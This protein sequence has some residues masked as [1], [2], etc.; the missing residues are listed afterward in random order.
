MPGFVIAWYNPTWDSWSYDF[1]FTRFLWYQIPCMMMHDTV[2]FWLHVWG[3]VNK[4]AFNNVHGY[5]HQRKARS[6]K[7]RGACAILNVAATAYDTWMDALGTSPPLAL[8]AWLA[9]RQNN[10]WAL[11]IPFHTAAIIFVMGHCGYELNLDDTVGAAFLALNP[12]LIVNK[13]T[14]STM[15]PMDHEMHHADP[16]VNFALFFTWW[17]EATGRSYPRQRRAPTLLLHAITTLGFFVPYVFYVEHAIWRSPLAFWSLVALQYLVPSIPRAFYQLLGCAA[18]RFVTRLPA[19]DAVRRDFEVTYA[20]PGAPGALAADPSKRYIF[21]YQP[22]GI[23]A[24]GA[25]YTF[26]GKGRGSPVAALAD[27][28]LAVLWSLPVAQQLAALCGCCDASWETLTEL[29]TDETPKSVCLLPG[30]YA[31]SYHAESYKVVLNKR[32]GF[33]RLAAATGASLVPVIGI[34]EPFVCG[35][36]CDSRLG[37]IFKAVLAYRPYPLKLVFGE[38]LEV[39]EGEKPESLHA[40]Y[41]QALLALAKAHDVPLVIAE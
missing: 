22:W 34:G 26:A 8:I 36:P 35:E 15:K 39:R 37:L 4:W 2:F 23:Q 33:A 14:A 11:F 28:K 17:D 9:F 1:S 16:R 25:W 38:P 24:R 7:N 32:R 31:E 30:G 29:L 40:R 27:C 18:A 6:G 10:F 41:C 19:W 5:H 20:P 21:C 13:L 3:H 12:F